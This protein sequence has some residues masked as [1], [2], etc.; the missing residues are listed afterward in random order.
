V[1]KIATIEKVILRLCHFS[2][3]KFRFFILPAT[4]GRA[5]SN[6]HVLIMPSKPNLSLPE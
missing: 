5:P 3:L 2:K 1:L 6:A 4:P